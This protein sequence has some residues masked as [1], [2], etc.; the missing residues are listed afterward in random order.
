MSLRASRH[1]RAPTAKRPRAPPWAKGG[2]PDP[3]PSKDG[4]PQ[5]QNHQAEGQR[6]N[7]KAA[8]RLQS[9]WACRICQAK[10]QRHEN[11]KQAPLQRNQKPAVSGSS[12]P[13]GWNESPVSPAVRL[14]TAR[15]F[16]QQCFY[17][18]GN[19]FSFSCCFLF[20]CLLCY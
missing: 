17:L 8:A 16:S 10:G 5:Q 9:Q 3:L 1:N 20:C 14:K 2:A 13:L 19:V 11:F 4:R 6:A 7:S 18:L 12:Q 15:A